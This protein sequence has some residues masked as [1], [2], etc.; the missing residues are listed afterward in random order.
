MQ[1][2]SMIPY[3]HSLLFPVVY[4]KVPEYL[5]HSFSLSIQLL[6][7]R[8]SQKIPSNIICTLAGDTCT[9]L[10]ISFNPTNSAI[11]LETLT[12]T[13]NDILSW[14]NMNKLLLNPSETEFLH[15]GTKPAAAPTG[16]VR[17]C[18]S[19]SHSGVPCQRSTRGS[20]YQR[21][22]IMAPAV[23]TEKTSRL[24]IAGTSALMSVRRIM[25]LITW[26]LWSLPALIL[27]ERPCLPILQ[28]FSPAWAIVGFALINCTPVAITQ[29][30][31]QGRHLRGPQGKRKKEKKKESKRKKEK[32]GKKK[33]RREL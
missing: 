16:E 28:T 9:Q 31:E 25:S 11:S 10:Y 22:A 21:D 33:E 17:G 26:C 2:Q 32:E 8:G 23:R 14:M 27:H 12:T 7:A 15:I 30:P 13:F 6:L 20:G 4:P 24:P 29:P 18:P 3:L 19:V 5:A 1:S